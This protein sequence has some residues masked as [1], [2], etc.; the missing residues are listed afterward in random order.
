[1]GPHIAGYC[2]VS[3]LLC[4]QMYRRVSGLMRPAAV[5]VIK[6]HARRVSIPDAGSLVDWRRFGGY[7]PPGLQDAAV[8][9]MHLSYFTYGVGGHDM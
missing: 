8:Y 4:M 3:V 7:L 2:T 9:F 6:A 1:M 5:G